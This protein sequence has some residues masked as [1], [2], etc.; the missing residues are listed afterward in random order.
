MAMIEA[1][2]GWEMMK[3]KVELDGGAKGISEPERRGSSRERRAGGTGQTQALACKDCLSWLK[4]S[5]AAVST[6]AFGEHRRACA[7]SYSGL[8]PLKRRARL[9]SACCRGPGL[10]PFARNGNAGG[11]TSRQT[12]RLNSACQ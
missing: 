8:V 12:W 10:V 5:L 6:E 3:Q 9:G 2:E 7:L 4:G 1:F 11:V